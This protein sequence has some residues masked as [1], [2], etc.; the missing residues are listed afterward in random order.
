MPSRALG[1][2]TVVGEDGDFTVDSA[3][4]AASL[5]L[6][7]PQLRE[8]MQAGNVLS[9]VERGEGEDAARYRLTFRYRER[10]FCIVIEPDGTPYEVPAPMEL[11]TGSSIRLH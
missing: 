1:R 10:H 4:V 6:S 9:T 2:D 5:Q 7:E 3:L 11:I 8:E